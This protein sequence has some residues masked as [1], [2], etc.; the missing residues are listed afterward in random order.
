MSISSC[1]LSE[2]M[3]EIPELNFPNV[4]CNA[5]SHVCLPIKIR[6]LPRQICRAIKLRDKVGRFYRMSDVDLRLNTIFQSTTV[7]TRNDHQKMVPRTKHK[8]NKIY[9]VSYVE[10]RPDAVHLM[11]NY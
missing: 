3:Q 8:K 5:G 10:N 1:K 4:V 11:Q 7:K 9:T 2:F 6:Q